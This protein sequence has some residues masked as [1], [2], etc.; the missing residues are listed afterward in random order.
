MSGMMNVPK[1][2][3]NMFIKPRISR[4]ITCQWGE[5]QEAVS[6]VHLSRNPCRWLELSVWVKI[7]CDFT[8]HLSST[9]QSLPP[10]QQFYKEVAAS[11][12]SCLLCS[13]R[14]WKLLPSCGQH[15]E[16]LVRLV[17]PCACPKCGILV[18]SDWLIVWA[19]FGLYDS[20]QPNGWYLQ[21]YIYSPRSIQV[22]RSYKVVIGGSSI[23]AFNISLSFGDYQQWFMLQRHTIAIYVDVDANN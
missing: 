22:R 8:W 23:S 14:E 4:G 3:L 17:L 15:A 19:T 13:N 16:A 6:L 12:T 10:W 5:L 1:H 20:W 11:R 7:E 2:A 9:L 21:I 18:K